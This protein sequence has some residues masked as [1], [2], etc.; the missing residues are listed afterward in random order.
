MPNN[1]LL[2][3]LTDLPEAERLKQLRQLSEP[4]RFENRSH[5]RLWARTS[6]L[7]PPGD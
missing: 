3:Y 1:E 5:W 6:Q 7:A 4:E 2:D